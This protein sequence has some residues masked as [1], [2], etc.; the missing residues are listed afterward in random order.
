M[1]ILIVKTSA[2][3]DIVHCFHI[4]RYLKQC[5]PEVYIGWVV[6]KPFSELVRAHPDVDRVYTI[7]SKRWRKKFFSRDT[8]RELGKFRGELRDSTYDLLIDFQGNVKSAIVTAMAKATQKIGFD[9]PYVAERPSTWTTHKRF[10]PPGNQNIRDDYLFLAQQAIMGPFV[11]STEI[12]PVVLKVTPEQALSN[13]QFLKGLPDVFEKKMLVFAGAA[14]KNK[15]LSE[16]DLAAFL[17][18]CERNM[19]MGILLAWGSPEEHALANRLSCRLINARV[20]DRL[21]LPQLQNLMSN[22]N[23]VVTMDSLPLH[24]AGSAQ[25]P[26]YSFFGPSDGQKYA[27]QGKIHSYYRGKCPYGVTFTRRCSQLRTCATGKC[28]REIDVATVFE[29]FKAWWERIPRANAL[30]SLASQ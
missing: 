5:I 14:W 29:S 21:P 19:G 4:A 24:L 3:G 2:L 9:K 6:E 23:V 27:P 11:S 25:V 15:Q 22:C 16:N 17:Q 28:L 26:T 30:L 8:W 1:R 13:V 18:M 10:I 7:E 20:I 12:D